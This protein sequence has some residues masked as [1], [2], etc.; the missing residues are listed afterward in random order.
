MAAR[1]RL[2]QG[3]ELGAWVHSVSIPFLQPTQT[4]ELQRE[5]EG[6]WRR[7]LELDRTWAIEDG[8]RF[9]GNG[10]AFT[11]T[12][13]LPGTPTGPCPVVGF[14]AISGI[15]V[16]PTHRRQALLRQLM[17]TILEDARERGECLA[18]LVSSEASIYG[19]FGFGIATMAARYV[20]D[21]R[22]AAFA[23]PVERP[24]LQLLDPAEASKVI[25]GLF[26]RSCERQPGQVNRTEAVW[27]D[28]FDD[29]PGRRQGASASSYLAGED[30]Y[31][32]WRTEERS[33]E[34]R[35]VVLGDLA[36]ETAETEAALWRFVLDL[37]LV[38]EVV[39]YPRPLDE[40]VRHR[41]V[42]PRQLRTTEFRDFLW[43]RVLDV[44]AALTARGYR[45]EG[46]LVLDV[47][48]NAEA[49]AVAGRWT[50]EA[51]PD[52]SA[53]RPA[54]GAE[55][56]DL[57]MGIA[58][59][60]ALLSGGTRASLLAAAERVDEERPGALD[61]ADALFAGRPAPLTITT[62]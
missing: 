40:P 47:R 8:G 56:T 21:T 44:P 55:R 23:A 7:H 53:C 37:D 34:Y 62:F 58:E 51:G 57:V 29:P 42:D 25:P 50:L 54:T 5:W 49:D 30:G 9:V 10:N 45:R 36:A 16:H 48:T 13:T 15:G 61:V 4:D 1:V 46:R 28:Q 19:R 43:L 26:E 60:S 17:R 12:V 39:A 22:E 59:L 14:A 32:S 33:D 2:I 11:R 41:L 52:G 38:R 3:D 20:I 27:L 35:R 31:A 18:G 24:D 6:H